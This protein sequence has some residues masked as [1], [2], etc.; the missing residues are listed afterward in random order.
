[1]QTK[2]KGVVLAALVMG[3]TGLGAAPIVVQPGSAAGYL[4]LPPASA[5]SGEGGGSTGSAAT[6]PGT[7]GVALQRAHDERNFTVTWVEGGQTCASGA[8]FCAFNTG[9]GF[10]T[11]R[12]SIPSEFWGITTTV[13]C[14]AKPTTIDCVLWI[15][16]SALL[17]V[18]V[19]PATLNGGNGRYVGSVGGRGVYAWHQDAGGG[20]AYAWGFNGTDTAIPN[21]GSSACAQADTNG[22]GNDTVLGTGSPA[23]AACRALG[24]GWRLPSGAELWAIYQNRTVIG[25]S[26]AAAAYWSSSE[27]NSS[28]AWFLHGSTVLHGSTGSWYDVGKL[29]SARVRCARS[30]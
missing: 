12:S 15:D 7:G 16:P 5:S 25:T 8:S 29:Y 13:N 20:T 3:M 4:Y 1:M 27:V 9:G 17:R 28:Y 11:L 18:G 30:L 19:G 23:N 14:I 21:C 2:I 26:L 10:A 6:G 22:P 24:T